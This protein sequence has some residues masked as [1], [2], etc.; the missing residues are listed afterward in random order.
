M[1]R[2]I[3]RRPTPSELTREAYPG[4]SPAST[5]NHAFL[6]GSSEPAHDLA[7]GARTGEQ[8]L[9]GLRKTRRIV[10]VDDERVDD[11]TTH[12]ALAQ[13]ARTRAR[14]YHRQRALPN[15]GLTADPAPGEPDDETHAT[16]RSV[17]Q[18]KGSH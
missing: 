2:K 10:W 18:R 4:S 7:M 5:G 13:A 17:D 6:T 16:P 8:F 1:S 15:D 3:T 12:P 9:E 11:V 14:S